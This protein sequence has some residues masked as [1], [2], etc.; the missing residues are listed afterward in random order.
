MKL[1]RAKL[2]EI[3]LEELNEVALCRDPENKG[4][5]SKCG[6][7]KVYSLS[8]K[9][10]KSAGVNPKYVKRGIVTG[11]ETKDGVPKT[12]AKYGMNTSDKKAAGRR[13]PTE[14]TSARHE[15]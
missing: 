5:F 13:T 7:G 8:S 14:K 1:T 4:Y 11:G 12:R 15:G 9:G 3:I 2:K 6:K 10:A